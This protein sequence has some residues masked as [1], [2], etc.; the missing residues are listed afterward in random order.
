[1]I[2][3]LPLLAISKLVM[4]GGSPPFAFGEFLQALRGAIMDERRER[5]VLKK[6]SA[7]AK[8]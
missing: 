6:E 7:N 4:A 3:K 2:R 5:D 8:L 1:M